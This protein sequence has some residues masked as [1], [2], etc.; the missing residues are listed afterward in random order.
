MASIDGEHTIF[1]GLLRN[2]G[3]NPPTII[4]GSVGC[5][6]SWFIQ[7]LAQKMDTHQVHHIR[8]PVIRDNVRSK[9][10]FEQKI[11]DLYEFAK[12][13]KI[14]IYIHHVHHMKEWAQRVLAYW[15]AK[16]PEPRNHIQWIAE[17]TTMEGLS[18][19]LLTQCH[20]I[21]FPKPTAD[22]V[23][24]FNWH[25]E[26]ALQLVTQHHRILDIDGTQET[27]A[28]N[29]M[30]QNGDFID[31][32]IQTITRDYGETAKIFEFV[33]DWILGPKRSMEELCNHMMD[34]RLLYGIPT[35]SWTIYTS[36]IADAY[37]DYRV[38][39]NHSP[40]KI[41]N[42]VLECCHHVNQSHQQ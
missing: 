28:H 8:I 2:A 29:Q 34:D 1:D 9:K 32:L 14:L 35:E 42:L 17:C 36:T 4:Y 38:N 23:G 40:T 30:K 41:L 22:G 19:Y 16:D 11:S 37:V 39:H 25:H 7:Q 27:D 13:R 20:V 10:Q 5:G 15:L 33:H 18:P 24:L 12:S 21:Y 31:K 26:N 6:K 3:H